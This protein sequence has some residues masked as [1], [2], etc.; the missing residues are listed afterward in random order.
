[1]PVL[2]LEMWSSE[3]FFITYFDA[4]AKDDVVHIYISRFSLQNTLAVVLVKAYLS[5]SRISRI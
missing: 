3:L 5:L 4:F 2:M 1:M